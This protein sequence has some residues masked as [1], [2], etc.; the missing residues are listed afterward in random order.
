MNLW[1]R[2]LNEGKDVSM[3]FL[4]KGYKSVAIYG[5][6]D[7]GWRLLEELEDSPISV[8]YVID[9]NYNTIYCELPVYSPSDDLP[10]IDAIIVTAITFFDEIK[11]KL[12]NKDR[13][14][15][16]LNEVLMYLE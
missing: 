6:A 14:I 4:E 1:L 12:D 8:K 16:S 2:I 3:Y 7:L 13:D 5:M 11:N 9:R 15:I 10:E